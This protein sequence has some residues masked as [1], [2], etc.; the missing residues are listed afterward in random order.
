MPET[1]FANP[2]SGGRPYLVDSK[3][4]R[5]VPLAKKKKAT[6]KKKAEGD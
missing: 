2:P 4:K 6:K 3:G 5:L 1:K